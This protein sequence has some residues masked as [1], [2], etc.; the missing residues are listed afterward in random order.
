MSRE[1]RVQ[2]VVSGTPDDVWEAVASGPGITAWFVPATVDAREDGEIT[3]DFGSGMI[4]RGRITVYDP[5]KRF[6]YELAA[7]D[8]AT[9]THEWLI[10]AGDDGMCIVR[11]VNGGFGEGGSWDDQ[12]FGMEAGW[13]LFLHN[14]QLFRAHFADLR[15]ASV[16][17][18]AVAGG[19]QKETFARYLDELGLEGDEEVRST[20]GP[21]LEGRVVGRV[22]GML[23]LL[24]ETPHSGIVFL[25]SEGRADRQFVS[26]YGYFFGD[27]ADDAAAQ[28]RP[29]W[30]RW[31]H[32]R[33]SPL[34]M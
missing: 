10:E 28:A 27:G 22:P 26:F 24:T 11:L 13:K 3:L 20:R 2:T 6:A 30:E 14:L 12:Y 4:E 19:G 18:N 16:I 29:E 33:F 15:C 32:E 34:A 23:T 17:V 7:E 1:I 8:G 25:A 9:L 21:A 5:P 31:L